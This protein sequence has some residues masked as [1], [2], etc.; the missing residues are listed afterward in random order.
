KQVFFAWKPGST[1]HAAS[2]DQDQCF[3]IFKVNI[4][5]TGLVQLTDG[6]WNDFDPCCLP[7][8]RLAFISERRGGYGRCHL[9]PVPTYTLFSMKEDGSDIIHLSYH[10]TNEWQPSVDNNGMIIYSR[11]DYVD[12]D[13]CIAHHPWTCYPDGRDPRTWHGNYPLPTTT[14]EG[15]NWPDGRNFRPWSEFNARAIPNSSKFVVTGAGHHT[16]AY[17]QLVM[18]DP[19]VK[20]DGKMSQ[21]IGI[22]TKKTNWGDESGPW[23]TAYPLSEQY[24]LA[25]YNGDIVFIDQSANRLTV[26]PLSA[27]SAANLAN[28]KLIDPIPVKVRKKQSD[29]SVQTFEGEREKLPHEAARLSVINVYNSDLPFPTGTKIKWLRVIQLIPKTTQNINQPQVCVASESVCRMSLGIV[30]VESDGSAHFQAPVDRCLMFQVLDSNYMAVQSMRSLTYVHKGEHLSCAGC[31]EDKW[32]TPPADNSIAAKRAPTQLKQEFAEALPV[33]FYRTAKPV[34]DAKCVSCHT[35]QKKGPNMSY[36]SLTSYLFHFCDGGWP[37]TN[38]NINVAVVGG[39]RSIPGKVGARTSKLYQHCLP[40]HHS[41]ALTA[42]ELHR[43]TL[44]LDMNSNELGSEGDVNGQKSGKLVWPTMD[45]DP[46]NPL[47]IETG[48]SVSVRSDK[49]VPMMVA[50]PYSIRA[51]AGNLSI[52][53]VCA[54]AHRVE[55]FSMR[56]QLLAAQKGKG[57]LHFSVGQRRLGAGM[58]IVRLTLDGKIF[59]ESV[60]VA[61]ESWL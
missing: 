5:G 48:A 25:S 35:Q 61:E 34:F 43:V 19:T 10:E 46:A 8:G 59:T 9:R 7:S 49:A 22:S 39:S 13:D 40:S 53:G 55:V 6:K 60:S 36:S 57:N 18:I 14:M 42:D 17:G 12:R 26:C 37:Y 33:S 30:P 50:K 44:W 54:R 15:S 47:G 56:G 2:W 52:D 27:T 51:A 23:A 28:F 58:F 4:D 16:E 31:H 32:T 3:H 38:G 24:F 45:V 20:D 1:N 11:W 41:V 21:V 29:I